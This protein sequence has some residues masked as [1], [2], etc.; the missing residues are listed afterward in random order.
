MGAEH[1]AGAGRL[2]R[3]AHMPDCGAGH[4]HCGL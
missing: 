1:S 4:R 2:R 3:L